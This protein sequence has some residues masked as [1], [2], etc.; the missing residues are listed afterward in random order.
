MSTLKLVICYQFIMNASNFDTNLTIFAYS[1]PTVSK[2]TSHL[3]SPPIPL[4]TNNEEK[5]IHSG[6]Q[7]NSNCLSVVLCHLSSQITEPILVQQRQR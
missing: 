4:A 7:K 3:Q 2:N 1:S 5:K 6:M